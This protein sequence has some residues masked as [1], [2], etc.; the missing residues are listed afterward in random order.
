[1]NAFKLTVSALFVFLF[2]CNNQQYKLSPVNSESFHGS[3]VEINFIRQTALAD[4][5]ADNAVL[6]SRLE[7]MLSITD[8]LRE[9]ESDQEWEELINSWIVLEKIITPEGAVLPETMREQN[10][11]SPTFQAE[12]LE[13]WVSI[14]AGLMKFS[15]EVRFADAIEKVVY[16]RQGVTVSDSLLKSLAYTHVFDKVYINVIGNS[17]V[18]FQH[19]TG[20]KVTL[21]QETQYPEHNVIILK[22]ECSDKRFLDVNIRIPSWA[23]NPT[24]THGNVKYVARPGEY[25]QVVRKW[26]NGDE[27]LIVLKN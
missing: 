6:L 25:C 12:I 22:C 9:M 17:A 24:V 15:G 20:G 16:G 2:S 21:I 3:Q 8:R 1:M 4:S 26:R 13:K 5:L 10:N 27:F 11:G 7:Q 19:T 18:S 14:N 23:E